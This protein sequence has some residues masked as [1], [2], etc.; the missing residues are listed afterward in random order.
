MSRTAQR[1]HN[2]DRALQRRMNNPRNWW[3][4]DNEKWRGIYRNTGTTCS[5]WCCR[6]VR[7]YYGPSMQE[8]RQVA[9]IER[10]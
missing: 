10:V 3:V 6:R 4:R 2:D 9:W 7:R 8:Q 1:R 5:S